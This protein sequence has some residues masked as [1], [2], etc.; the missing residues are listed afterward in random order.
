[1]N[2][3]SLSYFRNIL[4]PELVELLNS[5]AETTLF[6]PVDK[7]W[8]A[9]PP[10]ERMYLESKY[11]T[12]DLTRII[13]MHAVASKKVNYADSFSSGRNCEL[14]SRYHRCRADISDSDDSRWSSTRNHAGRRREEDDGLFR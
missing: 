9:L 4:T 13:N 8:D 11:A 5:T 3:P 1:M 14:M 7:A 10:Y 6:L 2:H 12:D